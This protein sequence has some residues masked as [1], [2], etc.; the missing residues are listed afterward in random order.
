MAFS[1]DNVVETSYLTFGLGETEVANNAVGETD[2]TAH[3]TI[4]V[5]AEEPSALVMRAGS[6]AFADVERSSSVVAETTSVAN[7][8]A[9]VRSAANGDRRLDLRAVDR[10]I[11]S[12]NETRAIRQSIRG[13][14]AASRLP[15]LATIEA[16][17]S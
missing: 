10:A 6:R 4:S 9:V 8:R 13:V 17:S 14:R 1:L 15:S 11:G 7:V 3:A 2:G 5:A 16:L 12:S